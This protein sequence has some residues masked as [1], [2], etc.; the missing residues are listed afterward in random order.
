MKK[1]IIFSG[2]T[3]GKY[4]SELLSKNRIR[5]SVCV[6]TD[7]GKDMMQESPYAEIYVGRMDKEEMVSFFAKQDQDGSLVVVDATH[8]YASRVTEN[9]VEATKE[10][11]ARYIRV[12]RKEADAGGEDCR[13]YA[14]IKA[15]A[16][17]LN[18]LRG[19]I[20]LTT[21]SKEL[22]EYLAGCSAD[23]KERTYV[24]VLPSVE[25]LTLCEKEGIRPDH[26]IAMHGPFDREL[27]EAILRQYD[28]RHLVTK[29][30]GS[31]GGFLK[32]LE[33]AHVCGAT[34]HLIVRP[35]KEEGVSTKEALSL[36]GI[37][38]SGQDTIIGE[39]QEERATAAKE[40]DRATAAKGQE[41]FQI[42]L[43]G[44]GM[45]SVDGITLEAA[46]AIEQAEAVFGA[47][48]LLQ[49]LPGPKKY[50][51]YRAGEII[52][53]LE[54]EGIRN[55]VIVFSGD[56]GFYSGARAM[57]QALTDWRADAA[58]RIL[59][60]I[61][62]FSALFARLGESYE[63][64][65]LWSLHGKNTDADIEALAKKAAFSEKTFVLLSGGEDVSKL[66][67][68]LMQM[69]IQARFIIGENLSY[70]N[71]SIRDLSVEEACAFRGEGIP[72]LL[73]RNEHPLKKPLVP[74]KRDAEFI[75]DVVP[76]TKETIRHESI[77]RLEPKLGDLLYDIGGG[78]GSVAIEAAG[79]DPSLRVIT[80]EKKREAADL[81]RANIEKAGLS[82]I[83]LLEGE[84]AALL[85]SMEKPDCVFIGGSGGRLSEIIALLH[86]KG[87]GIRFVINAVSLETVEEIRRVLKDYAP[88]NEEAVQIAVTNLK[89]A[90]DYHMMNAQN[91]VWIFSFTL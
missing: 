56:T 79:L 50:E 58:V 64:V 16:M 46:K 81:I 65:L 83:T 75:R 53:V 30:S 35:R 37:Q 26:I 19:N 32:K 36:L 87:G 12:L 74:V 62:S 86:A 21:G 15:C 77:L 52:P 57:K 7:Y 54:E 23:T 9:L 71:E 11:G 63:D 48:R 44:I 82:N 47:R 60:G 45:G 80:I 90:G 84:A 72:S 25:S 6:A 70:E 17:A 51:M 18:D 40:Q 78:T 39:Q 43:V 89:K 28:I 66:A 55:A 8:P 42:T 38:T 14:D 31:V 29:D 49:G 2:T 85:A 59:P 41:P 91:P 69:G 22:G 5:H 10:A 34:V 20:L 3:E 61:S 68:H 13:R 27:N 76:I 33:A 4:L 24:R 1:I 67:K 73:I 88:Q